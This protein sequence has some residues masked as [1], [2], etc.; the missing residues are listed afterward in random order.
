M[1]K[2]TREQIDDEHN[3]KVQNIRASYHERH[4]ISHEAYHGQLNAERERY[5]NELIANG[6]WFPPMD[7]AA[8]INDLKVRVEALEAKLV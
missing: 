5:L 7:L 2:K 1:V 6:Y 3:I 4:E 8:E